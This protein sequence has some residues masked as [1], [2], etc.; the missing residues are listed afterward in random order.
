MYPHRIGKARKALRALL[1]LLEPTST[2]SVYLFGSSCRPV[3][4][5]EREGNPAG[6]A[7]TRSS[8]TCLL[9]CGRNLAQRLLSLARTDHAGLITMDPSDLKPKS[10]QCY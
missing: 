10:V 5:K 6:A 8:Q 7:V 9:S 4:L 2:F 3:V 1:T